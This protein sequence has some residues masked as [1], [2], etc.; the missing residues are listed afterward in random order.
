MAGDNID[1]PTLLGNLA[2]LSKL[3]YVTVGIV[4]TEQNVKEAGQ[5]I[6]LVHDLGVADIRIIPAAQWKPELT[7]T[8]DLSSAIL[9]AHPILKYRLD[10][11]GK[12]ENIRSI[13]PTDTTKCPLVLD[14]MAVLKGYHYSCV[15]YMREWGDPIGLLDSE[16]RVQREKWYEQH[17]THLDPI[18]Q[19]NCLDV[20]VAYNNK[21]E[22][23]RV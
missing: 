21:A 18:C 2:A 6:K 4:L 8:L 1:Y 9:D 20:C 16:V 12:G 3:T 22:K 23:H 7:E 14:D 13:S 19:A 10:R 11:A 5:T 15:I 17:N